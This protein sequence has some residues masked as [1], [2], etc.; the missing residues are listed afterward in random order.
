MTSAITSSNAVSSAVPQY[1]PR[2]EEYTVAEAVLKF[3]EEKVKDMPKFLGYTAFWLGEALPNLPPQVKSF[4]LAMIDVKNFISATE[5]PKKTVEVWTALSKLWTKVTDGTLRGRVQSN[6]FWATFTEGDGVG[7]AARKLLE[8]ATALINSTYD[9][10]DFGSRFVQINH[11]VMTWI[12]GFNSTA[13]ILGSGNGAIEQIEALS[14]TTANDTHKRTLY[15]IKLAQ[16][17]SYLAVGIIGLGFVVTAAPVVPWMFVAPLT[18]GL[19]CT[20]GSYFYEKMYDPEQ[21]GKNLNPEA[22]IQNRLNR[23]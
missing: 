16:N 22:V 3:F 1:V 13:T 14:K 23:V 10:I 11:S 2:K 8:K 19:T 7:A 9:G 20:T 5:L 4:S 21:K 17:I 12:K 6:G 15:A 18:V